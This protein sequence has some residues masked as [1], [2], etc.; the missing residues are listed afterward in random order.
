[1]ADAN[2]KW[3]R[4]VT[5]AR[6]IMCGMT[7][8]QT[9]S[10]V[11]VSPTTVSNWTK[12]GDWSEAMREAST[13]EFSEMAAQALGVVKEAIAGGDVKTAK[14]YL[15]KV[16]PV[17]NGGTQRQQGIESEQQRNIDLSNLSDQELRRLADGSSEP[18]D[19]EFEDDE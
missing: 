3:Q 17:F 4:K 5:A 11:G 13:V 12:Q 8:K 9:A 15:S 2:S 1:M 18:I 6:Y 10:L 7:Q 14:W 16:H 19:A